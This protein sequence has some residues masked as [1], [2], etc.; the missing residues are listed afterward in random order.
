MDPI[1]FAINKPVTISVGVILIIL[2]GL[3]SVSAIP[4]QL[5]PNVDRPVI[6]ITTLWEG[7]SPGEI[8]H[9]VIEKQEEKLKSISGLTKM[10]SICQQGQGSIKLDFSIDIDKAEALIEVNEKLR[11]VS[12][13]PADVDEPVGTGGARRGRSGEAVAIRA[14]PSGHG[15]SAACSKCGGLRRKPG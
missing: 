10:T 12:S 3:L 15:D 2:A 9:D 8:Q 5:T 11:Q 1:R 4:I 13:Y 6:S 14:E 7:V